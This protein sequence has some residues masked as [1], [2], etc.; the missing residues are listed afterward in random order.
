MLHGTIT[1]GRPTQIPWRRVSEL[2][3]LLTF[4]NIVAEIRTLVPSHIAAKFNF[5]SM[6]PMACSVAYICFATNHTVEKL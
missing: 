5:S 1:A 3:W 6:A 4:N 2:D